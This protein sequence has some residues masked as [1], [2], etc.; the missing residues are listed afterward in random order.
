[1][2]SNEVNFF[3]FIACIIIGLLITMNVNFGKESTFLD[4]DQYQ[5]AYDERT[6]LQLEISDL[7]EEYN[8]LNKKIN[9]YD[10][11]S[12]NEY[13]V[14]GEILSELEENKMM[15]GL[16]PVIGNG[17]R[18]TLNDAS[19]V[20]FGGEYT[21]KMLIHNQDIV[22]VINDLRN[23]GAEAIA[24]NG[25]RVVYTSNIRCGGVTMDIDGIKLVAPFY[26]TALGNENVMK[27]Y[28]DKPESQIKKLQIRK[29]YV[30]IET[31][32]NEKL[33]S[34]NGNILTKYLEPENED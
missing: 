5:K 27:N 20:R 13:E 32:I 6:K 9:K 11:K 12:K 19:E 3:I 8:N 22:K 18:I 1:M 26:I 30:N 34:Y 7:E 24:I 10:K 15:L 16:K 23:A 14:M 29:C 4:I 33:P 28:M 2:R 31:V 21:S 17:V 25:Y